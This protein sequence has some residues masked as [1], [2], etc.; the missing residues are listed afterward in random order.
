MMKVKLICD[1]GY[2]S[3]R[4]VA[5]PIVVDAVRLHDGEFKIIFDTA[6]WFDGF[7]F[8]ESDTDLGGNYFFTESEVE[9]L[10]E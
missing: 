7:I 3:F 6:R 10:D 2:E 8:D 4:D 1:G 5:F 9:V